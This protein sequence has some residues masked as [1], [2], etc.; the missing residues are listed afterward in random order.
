MNRILSILLS[1]LFLSISN[2]GSAA[3]ASSNQ[4]KTSIPKQKISELIQAATENIQI[5][6]LLVFQYAKQSIKIA[7]EINDSL[8]IGNACF[9]MGEA[10]YY[11]SDYRKAID[12]YKQAETLFLKA[13]NRSKLIEVYNS[14][15]LSSFY[16]QEYEE[17]T[18]YYYTGLRMA[19]LHNDQEQMAHL[20]SNIGMVFSRMRDYNTAINNY[21]QALKINTKLKSESNIASSLNGLGVA[22]YNLEKYDS[23]QVYYLKALQVFRKNDNREYEAIILNNLANILSKYPDSLTNAKQYYNQA[24]LV[25]NELGNYRN[26]AYALEGLAG[27]YLKMKNHKK[28]K[29]TYLEGLKLL[30]KEK[31]DYM[32]LQNY[33]SNLSALYEQ[34]GDYQEALKYAQLQAKYNDSLI[35]ETR[36]NQIALLEKQFQT[37][38]KEAEIGKLKAEQ[39]LI[40]EK[41]TNE[42]YIR[43]SG[44]I[45]V[46]LLLVALFYVSLRY[47]DKKKT[48][49]LLKEKN[50]QISH[51]EEELRNLNAA[52]NKFFSIIAHDLKSPFH[53]TMGYSQLLNNDYDSLSEADRKKF[54]LNIFQSAQTIF[55]LLSN[56]LDWSRSQT[57]RISFNPINIEFVLIYDNV[58]ALLQNIAQKKQI[59]IRALFNNDICVYADPI[60]LETVLRNLVSNAIKYSRQ[61]GEIRIEAQLNDRF[62]TMNVED[63]GMGMPPKLKDNLFRIDSK[64]K[65]KGTQNED[66]SGI[67]LIL[68]KELIDRH[69]GMIHVKSIPNQGSS[70]K[71]TLP[72]PNKS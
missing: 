3:V 58:I 24:I 32:I 63:D 8:A 34:T 4:T 16:L 64:V 53:I 60:M 69:Q 68:C 47:Y 30:S 19:E 9:L 6:S 15:G 12:Y 14:L 27:V 52:K 71:V 39:A 54:A 57:N 49:E 46:G 48:S 65:Q 56:L 40:F 21:K 10:C 18:Q 51:S 67:G 42:R 33:Y 50:Q 7:E 5:D 28:A 17:A 2:M 11:A 66:G 62:F 37:E 55:S 25:F 1:F 22:Y 26:I 13:S 70:F 59:Q 41:Q 23:S 61:G 44:I 36:I 35:N 29:E 20:H 31:P 45:I 72:Q 43:V 38:K